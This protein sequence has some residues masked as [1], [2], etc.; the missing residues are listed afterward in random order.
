VSLGD[1]ASAAGLSKDEVLDC[2]AAIPL[3]QVTSLERLGG[4]WFCDTLDPPD[5]MAER[6]DQK[7]LLADAIEALPERDRVVVTLYYME[8]LRLKEIGQILGLSESRVSRVLTAAHF[9]LREYL[10]ARA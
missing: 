2:L 6:E 1:L 4:E 8:D 3:T 10:R 7:Q 5:V 9:Q